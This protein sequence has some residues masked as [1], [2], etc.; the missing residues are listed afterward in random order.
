M[1]TCLIVDDSS[2][3]RK[4]IMMILKK[5]EFDIH[6]AENGKVAL[7]FCKIDMPDI[8]VLD[9]N[10]PVMTGIEFLTHLR[11]LPGGGDPKVLFCTTNAEM[12]HVQEAMDKGADE[13]IMKPFTNQIIEEKLAI[14]GIF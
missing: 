3:I 11:K 10:M 12:E 5:F 9:W 4:A 1:I 6:E 7:D 2:T 13:Y 8:I 14:I